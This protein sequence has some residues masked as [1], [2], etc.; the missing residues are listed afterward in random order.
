MVL[1]VVSIPDPV[2]GV[3][4]RHTV[5]GR[6]LYNVTAVQAVLNGVSNLRANDASGNGNNGQYLTFTPSLARSPFGQPGA[7]PDDAAIT[8]DN[9]GSWGP[10]VQIGLPTTMVW[11]GNITLEWW[12]QTLATGGG[13]DWCVMKPTVTDALFWRVGFNGAMQLNWTGATPG[14]LLDT[15]AGTL[16]RDGAWHHYAFV[17]NIATP[18]LSN[19]YR[20]GVALG[21]SITGSPVPE[22]TS[23]SSF[24]F[25]TQLDAPT[26][27][28]DEWALYP[29]ALSAARVAAHYAA[30]TSFAAYNA[31]VTADAPAIYYHLDEVGGS[32]GREPALEIT[33][34]FSIVEL[35]PTG[36]VRSGTVGTQTFSWQPRLQAGAESADETLVTVPT[37]ELVLPA[38]YTIGTLTPD[39]APG[40]QWSDIV[41]WWDDAYQTAT[42][43]AASYQYAPGAHLVYQPTKVG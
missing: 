20:D 2:P 16:L 39:L 31:A 7:L 40:D 41:L 30:R 10:R 36:F 27:G 28:M 35:V 25:D 42:E 24:H 13:S 6:Y 12:Y 22:F 37:P 8:F 15:P 23:E 17:L 3:D 38:G 14:W 4:W 21:V 19:I 32:G 1:H 26:G 5:P 29:S 18:A 43:T 9:P 33:D 34:G 11:N